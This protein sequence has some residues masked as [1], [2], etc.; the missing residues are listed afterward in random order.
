MINA[1][2]S[3]L[4]A[5]FFW[6]KATKDAEEK[7]EHSSWIKTGVFG[8]LALAVT[9]FYIKTN[10]VATVYQY[11]DIRAIRGCVDS[12]NYGEVMDSIES[13]VIVNKFSDGIT[14]R[15]IKQQGI[16]NK[17]NRR[18]SKLESGGFY[19]NFDLQ[20]DEKYLT[21]NFLTRDSMRMF[22]GQLSD[23][24]RHALYIENWTNAIPSLLPLFVTTEGR[25]IYHD[26]NK[27][28]YIKTL[29]YDLH[30]LK[31]APEYVYYGS[32]Y[33]DGI[34]SST[35]VADS[36]NNNGFTYSSPNN[37]INNLGFLSAVDVSQYT[38]YLK[39]N[40]SY[41]IKELCVKY[42]L[43]IEIMPHDTC[44]TTQS[45]SFVIKG[46]Y[47]NNII[48]NL[49]DDYYAFHVK[50]PTLANLQLIRSLILTTLLTALVSLFFINLFYRIRKWAVG[51]K[52]KHVAEINAD[53]VAKFKKKMRILLY[54]FLILIVYISYRIFINKPYYISKNTGE[55][56]CDY[57]GLILIV[58]IVIL[59]A[60]IYVMFRGAYTIK[61]KKKKA[62]K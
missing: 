44:M 17:I 5:L 48:N 1:F 51:F 3:A 11:M 46:R 32:N 36:T 14:E 35:F 19:I 33:I 38:Y 62:K 49:S 7:T 41:N 15:I 27:G 16:D 45:T 61:K 13:V 57:W 12:M 29:E 50:L 30:S 20:H 10:Q 4:V 22:R 54:S 21:C 8:V 25:T 26:I 55:F 43:P 60:I 34:Y 47:L 28:L 31:N 59:G 42:D 24:C 37:Y 9:C 39:I 53:K 58:F 52:E 2:I 6:K 18:F 56:L 40:S 23:S